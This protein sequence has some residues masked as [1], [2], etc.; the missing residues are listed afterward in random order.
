[1]NIRKKMRG[2]YTHNIRVSVLLIFTLFTY[3]LSANSQDVKVSLT[4]NNK[5][6]IDVLTEIEKQTD[7]LFVYSSDEI[8]TN[9]KVSV[10]ANNES[11]DK[12]LE[13][14]FFNTDIESKIEGKNILLV[15]K[16]ENIA[17]I[18]QSVWS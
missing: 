5:P 10:R 13:D 7:Y 16:Q 15:K 6:V 14:I 4:I 3:S 17:A 18:R 1:M 9:R 12:V 11:I 8:S 2:L